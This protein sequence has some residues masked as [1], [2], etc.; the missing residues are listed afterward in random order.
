MDLDCVLGQVRRQF[1]QILTEAKLTGDVEMDWD[2]TKTEPSM[3][4]VM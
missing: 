1:R 2:L 4:S 3:V